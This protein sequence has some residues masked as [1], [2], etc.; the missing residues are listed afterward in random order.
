MRVSDMRRQ[1][2]Y[3]SRFPTVRD[4][5]AAY[6]GVKPS[7][8]RGAAAPKTEEDFRALFLNHGRAVANG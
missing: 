2:R 1:F 7:A 5:V 4:M 3:W 6:L 8:K